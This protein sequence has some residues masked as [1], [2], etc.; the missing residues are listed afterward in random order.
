MIRRDIMV[1]TTEGPKPATIW[2]HAED[3]TFAAQAHLTVGDWW[4]VIHVPTTY[5]VPYTACGR[6]K[7]ALALAERLTRECPSAGSV[8]PG[9]GTA[10]GKHGPVAGMSR[11][12]KMELRAALADRIAAIEED[13]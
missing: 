2:L 5:A 3:A 13:A 8:E 12:L 11:E 7:E 4:Q 9:K 1:G 6:R 10:K